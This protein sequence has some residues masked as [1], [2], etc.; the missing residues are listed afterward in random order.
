MRPFAWL[1]TVLL[2]AA[3][4]AA[5]AQTEAP[6]AAPESASPVAAATVSRV[7]ITG[8]TLVETADILEAVP[9]E[10]GQAFSAEAYRAGAEAIE[11]LYQ[12]RGFQAVVPLGES[13]MTA[14]GL[15]R[16]SVT[17]AVV[18]EIG[19]RGNRKTR[20]GVIR[21]V[22]RLRP[23]ELYRRE[24]AQAD[25]RALFNLGIFRD[26]TYRLEPGSALGRVQVVYT[27]DEAKT[28]QVAAGLSYSGSSGIIGQVE[29]VETNLGGQANALAGYVQSGG[30][31]Y[32][33]GFQVACLLYTSRCV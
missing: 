3:C 23:G 1:S 33:S 14:D 20:T 29:L 26:V 11:K 19:V 12:E 25:V 15:V 16:Y 6:V 7:E 32:R 5:V 9:L 13:R 30:K 4:S 22:V 24:E 31:Y 27:V 10:A 2:A 17:E 18:E 8:N 28:G 21:R